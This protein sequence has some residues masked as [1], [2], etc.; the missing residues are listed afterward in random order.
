M[1]WE[2]L[3]RAASAAR[4]RAHAPYSRFTVGAA[5]RTRR[6][7]VYAGCNVE[8]RSYGATVCAERVALGSALAAGERQLTAVL[9]LAE[10][11]PPAPPCGICLQCL[12]EL[13]APDLPVR[14]VN[15]GGETRDLRLAE[16]L[17]HP[18]EL[19]RG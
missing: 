5:I 10:A 18:F 1:D 11:S 6:G 19:P 15:P 4:Q 12:A 3:I 17:P 7:D 16:L 13:A 8:N 2:P 14:L 9:V